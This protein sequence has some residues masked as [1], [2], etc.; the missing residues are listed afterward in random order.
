[1]G[2]RS[3]VVLALSELPTLSKCGK[4]S[5]R[6]IQVHGHTVGASLGPQRDGQ[7]EPVK[8]H[9]EGFPGGSRVP[10]V[11]GREEEGL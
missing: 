5:E 8:L 2:H 7:G 3:D 10:V 1:M 9:L 6:E 11:L 4:C